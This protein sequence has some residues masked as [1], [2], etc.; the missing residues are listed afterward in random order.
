M[1]PPRPH[2]TSFSVGMSTL[3]PGGT[4]IVIFDMSSWGDDDTPDPTD[5][6]ELSEGVG[7]K[8]VK[9]MVVVVVLAVFLSV[10]LYA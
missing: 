2:K 1:E 9:S 10:M 6:R 4:S 5:A 8:E 3:P 7:D